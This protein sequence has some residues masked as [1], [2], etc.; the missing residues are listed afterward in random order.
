MI[1]SIRY[2]QRND[3]RILK[4]RSEEKSGTTVT[5]K[6]DALRDD[7][8]VSERLNPPL[9]AP[10]KAYQEVDPQKNI[11]KTNSD[12][13]VVEVRFNPLGPGYYHGYILTTDRSGS[14]FFRGGPGRQPHERPDIGRSGSFISGAGGAASQSSG[15][16][17]YTS[18]NSGNSLSAGSGPGGEGQNVGLFGSI[19][20]DHGSYDE[21]ALD[22]QKNKVPSVTVSTLDGSC[23]SIESRMT[24]SAGVITQS[25][26]PYNPLVANSNSVAREILESVGHAGVESPVWAPGWR[27]ELKSK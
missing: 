20:V 2:L 26:T 9:G 4:A 17:Q 24:Q 7:P 11:Q 13:C 16:D 1:N 18:S 21:N 23:D 12:Q 3:T 8:S 6:L 15:T 5:T 10:D 27:T 25:R 19:V 14:D 22:W